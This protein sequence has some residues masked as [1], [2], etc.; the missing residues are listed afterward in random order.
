MIFHSADYDIRSMDRDWGFRVRGLFD[1]SIAAAFAGSE[2]L[3]LAAVLKEYLDVEVNKD[4]KL[5]RADWSLRP[6]PEEMLRYAAEDVLHLA[7]LKA[8]LDGKLARLG[9]T[10]WVREEVERLA[11]VRIRPRTP[12][13]GSSRSRA[14]ATWTGGD[15]RC[16]GL[17]MPSG[18]TRR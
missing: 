6:L 9:R 5:Q 12:S 14:A 13:G 7:R 16:C 4:K 10:A 11:R 18:R 8:T 1:T 2:R 3:G 17:S 15:S